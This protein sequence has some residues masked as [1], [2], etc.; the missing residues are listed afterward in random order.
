M[1]LPVL[2]SFRRCPYAMRARLAIAS[3][4][5]PCMLREVVLRNKPEALLQAS[6]KGT[7]P[8]LVIGTHVIDESLDIM[9]WALKQSD[10]ESLLNPQKGDLAQMLALIAENDGAF[11]QA[12][13]RYK[14][15]QRHAEHA[16]VGADEFASIHRDKGAQWLQSLEQRLSQHPYLFGAQ[17]S[18]ADLAIAPFVRQYAH[19]D[20][21]WFNEQDWPNLLV[22]LRRFLESTRFLRVMEKYEPW[23]PQRPKIMFPPPQP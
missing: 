17:L 15:P 2:Y 22:W 23:T 13:D 12:L 9:L 20:I 5:Q 21:D 6:P 14:Y 4:E 11:K 18:L 19:T 3:S 10:P 1:S 16:E 7:V 8:V